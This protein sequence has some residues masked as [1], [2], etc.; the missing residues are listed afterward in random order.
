MVPSEGSSSGIGMQEQ[1]GEGNTGPK[2][3]KP[4][5]RYTAPP[6]TSNSSLAQQVIKKNH[7]MSDS[8]LRASRI[9]RFIDRQ[10]QGGKKQ[11]KNKRKGAGKNKP[12]TKRRAANKKNKKAHA[13][14]VSRHNKVFRRK[15][16]KSK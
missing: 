4:S 15:T 11:T 3:N 1:E 16:R 8:D 6:K 9:A 12:K 2:M 5:R 14:R 13:G 10:R 7:G